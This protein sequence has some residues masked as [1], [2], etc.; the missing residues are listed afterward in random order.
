MNSNSNVT[1]CFHVPFWKMK[2]SLRLMKQLIWILN[3]AVLKLPR[4]WWWR[5][6]SL[7]LCQLSPSLMQ[8]D[9]LMQYRMT[10]VAPHSVLIYY[11]SCASTFE[12]LV[13]F[14]GVGRPLARR[15][16]PE[17]RRNPLGLSLIEPLSFADSLHTS[18]W[19]FFLPKEHWLSCET[20]IF[21]PSNELRFYWWG[22]VR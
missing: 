14:G 12:L 21:N 1:R 4:D 18:C 20:W 6:E 17:I 3:S 15:S 5:L 22:K 10:A 7:V 9:R 8:A 13:A 16:A 11:K 2:S 19:G